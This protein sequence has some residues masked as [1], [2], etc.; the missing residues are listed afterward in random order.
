MTIDINSTE[1]KVIWTLGSRISPCEF[2]TVYHSSRT[3]LTSSEFKEKVLNAM[4]DKGLIKR[5]TRHDDSYKITNE[6]R[7]IYYASMDKTLLSILLNTYAEA[8]L[9]TVYMELKKLTVG[10]INTLGLRYDLDDMA[11]SGLITKNQTVGGSR[12]DTVYSITLKGKEEI[13]NGK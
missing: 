12:S 7:D 5:D 2:L 1:G 11:T 10:Y 9:Y 13:I 8:T 6:G 4:E 3:A